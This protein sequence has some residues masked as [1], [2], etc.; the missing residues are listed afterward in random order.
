MRLKSFIRSHYFTY[1]ILLSTPPRNKS[2]CTKKLGG[3]G[4]NGI[5]LKWIIGTHGNWRNQNPGVCFLATSSTLLPIQPMG[6][7]G[8]GVYCLACSSKTDTRILVFSIVLGT[9]YLSY[10]KSIATFTLTFYEYIISVLAC[11]DLHISKSAE[12]LKWASSKVD[13]YEKFVLNG[14]NKIIISGI[15]LTWDAPPIILGTKLLWPGASSI[16]KCLPSVSK[17]P[18]PTSTVLPFSRSVKKYVND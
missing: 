1:C 16:V 14:Q 2:L 13:F 10:L 7:I 5:K 11:V 4:L 6:Q 8:S 9:R 18:R 12:N 17:K 3:L 15:F